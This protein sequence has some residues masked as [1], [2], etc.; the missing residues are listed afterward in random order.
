MWD[1]YNRKGLQAVLFNDNIFKFL[2]NSFY[3]N[4]SQWRPEDAGS[5]DNSVV[6]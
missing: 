3:V 1:L 6:K 5:K 4:G 2:P